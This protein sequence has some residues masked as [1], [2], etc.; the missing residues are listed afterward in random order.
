MRGPPALLVDEISAT[1][2]RGWERGR[3]FVIGLAKN[4]SNLVKFSERDDCYDRVRQYLKKL[5]SNAEALIESRLIPT[6]YNQR[7]DKSK[8]QFSCAILDVG[9]I[10]LDNRKSCRSIG[11]R[12]RFESLQLHNSNCDTFQKSQHF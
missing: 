11:R 8:P 10:E 7:H 12:L 1:N 4:H 5:I 9:N 6:E 3:N 2:G